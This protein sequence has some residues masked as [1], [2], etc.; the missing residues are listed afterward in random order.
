[1]C[2]RDR[3]ESL[4]QLRA[5]AHDAHIQIELAP[6]TTPSGVDTQED[7]DAIQEFLTDDE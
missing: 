6:E 2:I 3:T 5:L 7:F 1:M 4:E